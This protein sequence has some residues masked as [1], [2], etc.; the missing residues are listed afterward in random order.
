[1]KI[2][3]I[4]WVLESVSELKKADELIPVGILTLAEILRN[5]GYEV[6]IYNINKRINQLKYGFNDDK[7]YY[8]IADELVKKNADIYGI[9]TILEGYHYQLLVAEYIKKIKLDATILLG[10]PQASIYAK[11]TLKE[12]HYIDYILRGEGENSIISF[13]KLMEGNELIGNVPGLTYRNKEDEIIFNNDTPLIDDLDQLPYISYDLMDMEKME[14]IPIEVGRGCPFSCSFCSSSHYFKQNFRLK[15]VRRLISEIEVLIEKY[16]KYN[17]GFIHDLFT[18]DKKY[19]LSFCEALITRGI[20]IKWSCSARADK[21]DFEM[22]DIMHQAGCVGL[23][24]GIESGSNIM[25]KEMNKNLNLEIAR[26]NMDYVQK[27]GIN[28]MASFVIGFPQERYE[29]IMETLKLRNELLKKGIQ[30]ANPKL[31]RPVKGSPIYNQYAL[32]PFIKSICLHRLYKL[33]SSRILDTMVSSYPDIF[34]YYYAYIPEHISINTLI[35]LGLIISSEDYITS[36]SLLVEYLNFDFVDLLKSFNCLGINDDIQIYENH[37]LSYLSKKAETDTN[38]DVIYQIAVYER[39]K[40]EFLRDIESSRNYD[41]LNLQLH[42]YKYQ[43]DKLIHILNLNILDEVLSGEFFYLFY[44]N[45]KDKHIHI[46]NINKKLFNFLDNYIKGK[47]I[48]EVSEIFQMEDVRKLK[49][50]DVIR[51]DLTILNY[52]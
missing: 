7:L 43:V 20:N 1:M 15:S 17:F 14:Y 33:N 32:T 45:Y 6:E 27:K 36:Q 24:F 16:N 25:Q 31:L 2:C 41:K 42:S 18:L 9:S 37:Y 50:L 26:K 8:A 34:S 46:L 51:K 30:S 39:D 44:C 29:D 35:A 5:N 22:I 10:G 47:S 40:L 21:L 19:I 52:S 28:I 48:D 11:E 3:F 12:F 13:M 4:P 38:I 23:F 49:V